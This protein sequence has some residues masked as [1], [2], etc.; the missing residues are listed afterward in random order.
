MENSDYLKNIIQQAA[1]AIKGNR[2]LPFNI[3]S[4][5]V[6]DCGFE[7]LDIIDF[8]F[9]LQKLT[10]IELDLTEISTKMSSQSGRRFNDITFQEIY[11]YL[12]E[13]RNK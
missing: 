11:S 12:N 8:F 1:F 10:N 9:E 4:K 2:I 6:T 7:S 13:K 5:L 3:D